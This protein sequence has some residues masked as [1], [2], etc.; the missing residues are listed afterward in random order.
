MADSPP[1]DRSAAQDDDAMDPRLREAPKAQS[2]MPGDVSEAAKPAVTQPDDSG[3]SNPGPKPMSGT[4]AS[5]PASD[6][7]LFVPEMTNHERQL[8]TQAKFAKVMK[9]RISARKS[10][11]ANPSISGTAAP[12]PDDASEITATV[13]EPGSIPRKKDEAALAFARVKA[14]RDRKKRAGTLDM[15]SEIAYIK[16]HGA[17]D[18]RLRKLEADEEYDRESSEEE[19]AAISEARSDDFTPLE[20]PGAAHDDLDVAERPAKRRYRKRANPDDDGP[21]PKK[22]RKNATKTD[23]SKKKAG[24]SKKKARGAKSKDKKPPP[25]A[26]LS[27][28]MGTNVFEDAAATA[29][30]PQQPTSFGDT[31]PSRRDKALA[32]LIASVPDS[33]HGVACA[34]KQLLNKAIMDFTGQGS[35]KPS[36]EGD[37]QWIVSGMKTTLKHYQVLGTAFMR[38]REDSS[39]QPKGGILADEMGLGKTIMMLANIQNGRLKKKS[40]RRCTLI[41]ASRA[42][43]TQWAQEIEKHTLNV[44]EHKHLG[45]RWVR[46]HAGHRLTSGDNISEMENYDVVLT[47]YNEILSSYPST[48]IPPELVT[49]KQKEAWW[50]DFFEKE[51]GD[52]H[53][54]RWLRV[55][56]DEA[57]A[58]KNH[59]STTSKACI[60]LSAKHCWAVSGTPIQ[61]HIGE[62][63]A[64][65][66]FIKEP[67]AGGSYRLFKENFVTPGDPT[68]MSRL[69]VLLNKVMVRRTHADV[70]FGARLLDLPQPVQM[71]FWVSFSRLE[72]LIY[73]VV[74]KRF[75]ERINTISKEGGLEKKYH[76][77]WTLILRLRQLCS[78]PFLIQGPICD[79]LN[80][81]DFEK[82]N[83][84]I[85]DEDDNLEEGK[86]LLLHLRYML[87]QKIAVESVQGGMQGQQSAVVSEDVAVPMDLI[88]AEGMEENTGGK[89]GEAIHFKK[90][91]KSLA[92]SGKWVE[93][94]ERSVCA[95]C[96]QQPPNDPVITSCW[97]IY[98]QSCLTDLQTYA[99]RRGHDGATC[100]ECGELYASQSP[101]DGLDGFGNEGSVSENLADAAPGK[102]KA[103]AKGKKRSKGGDME[104][105]IG[106]NGGISPSAKTVAAKAQIL[107]WFAEDPDC[108]IIVFTQFLPMTRIL[109]KIC[110]T[111]GWS[112]CKY[113]GDMSHDSREKAIEEFTNSKQILISSLKSGGLGLNLTQASR[114]IC[115]D[116]WWNNSVE[117]QAFCRVFR[118]GQTKTTRFTKLVV[119]D[120]IDAAMMA[121][122]EN[123]QLEIDEAMSDSRKREISIK[124]L[125]KLFGPVDEDDEGR[126]FIFAEVDDGEEHLRVPNLDREDEEQDMGDEA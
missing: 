65:F 108:K 41:V 75:V 43:I 2:G 99:A 26:N 74:K 93:I 11:L 24:D 85:T 12:T 92:K 16:A 38:R 3:D 22:P 87:A 69:Q 80:Q 27:S 109:E 59:L 95:G 116:P 113:T 119:R 29:N 68:G 37:G 5:V 61:N 7:D 17:E 23:G 86:N 78:H 57:Q 111:E 18:V 90:Y 126:P 31:V 58:I 125:M 4:Q 102:D 89:F 96:K 62:L 77:I 28:I 101:I 19:G 20:T 35:V 15:E 63:Y 118:I 34:D 81:E 67:H 110:R 73:Q 47:T 56:L 55:V 72:R 103:K 50:S 123:K 64:F 60:S 115:L 46:N 48:K 66:K 97:H 13:A 124:D 79:I 40:K 106:M 94:K 10:T 49:A 76:H 33:D 70:L 82:L 84:I 45:L 112:C 25:M 36:N 120:T 121:M 32:Q 30:L 104:D 107:E 52:F 71:T 122:K 9:A 100:S 51:K 21:A 83:G 8:Q 54:V 1:P 14:A 105:W 98:C 117:Q 114:V 91:L 39:T 42:L 53:R 6:D 44:R 88:D